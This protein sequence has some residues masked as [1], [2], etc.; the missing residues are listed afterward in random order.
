[1]IYPSIFSTITELRA[2]MST[3]DGGTSIGPYVSMNLDFRGPDE[4]S[5]R[6][7]NRKRFCNLLGF[8]AEALAGSLQVHGTEILEVTKAGITEGFDALI[9]Q[10]KGLLISVSIADCTPI[11]LADPTTGALAAIHAGWRGTVQQITQKTLERLRLTYGVQAQN[12]FAWIGP[13]IDECSFEVGAEVAAQFEPD[14]IK[15]IEGNKQY[16]VDLKRAN[17][18][19]L[20]QA[21]VPAAH[22]EIDQRSTFLQTQDFFSYRAEKGV[23][24][25]MLAAIGWEANQ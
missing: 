20:L 25:R 1:M 15:A 16:Y 19:Q 10:K 8:E 23:T 21:G 22:I 11:L 3:R 14:F 2:G 6:L 7:E 9:T 18:D 17:W 13:C 12:C 24:G 4:E 5:A